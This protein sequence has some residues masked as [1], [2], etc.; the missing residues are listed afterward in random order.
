[1]THHS[2]SHM[3][4]KIVGPTERY[5]KV[6][7]VEPS[8]SGYLL[9]ALEVDRRPPAGFFIESRAKKE[10]IKRLKAFAD[11][12]VAA[13]GAREATVFKAV[14][15]PPGRGAYLKRRPDI[16]VARYDVVLL[17]EFADPDRAADMRRSEAWKAV[18]TDLERRARRAITVT[19]ANER[20]IGPVDHTRDGVFL[21]N[22]FFADEAARNLAVWEY[23]A[24]WFQD[25]TGLDNSTLLMP[26]E[27]EQ[28]PYTVIN[29]CRWD[30]LM[31]ILPSLLLKRDF[32]RFVLA[33]FEANATAAIPILYRLA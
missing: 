29:H 21:F 30:G 16:P 18:A 33:N 10:I 1:M 19:A 6:T 13:H 32:H 17:A 27:S 15:I 23:T 24:G 22:Y 28:V 8:R 3:A 2:A 7:L 25:Q 4:L 14:L 11:D 31:D 12:L 26:L 5:P 20:R 9:L